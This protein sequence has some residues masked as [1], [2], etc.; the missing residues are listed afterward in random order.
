MV[1]AR[2]IEAYT[3]V[4]IRGFSYKLAA[5][6]MGITTNAIDHRL[7]ELYIAKP[8]LKPPKRLNKK[9]ISVADVKLYNIIRKF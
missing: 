8:E 9:I 7:R 1:T 3:M 2:Q 6:A 4:M 5:S